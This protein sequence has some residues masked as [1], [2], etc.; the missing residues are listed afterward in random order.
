VEPDGDLVRPLDDV[1]VRQ[2][3]TLRVDDDAGAD[4]GA[5]ALPGGIWPKY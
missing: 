5:L 4:A 3:M 1:E 2:D